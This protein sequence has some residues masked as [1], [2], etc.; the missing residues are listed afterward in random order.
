MR[1]P[2]L[3][4]FSLSLVATMALAQ[5]AERVAKA[6]EIAERLKLDDRI[7]ALRDA[8]RQDAEASV[9]V[10]LQQFKAAGLSEQ[11]YAEL[12]QLAAAVVQRI[13][14]SSYGGDAKERFIL[15]LASRAE[16][17]ELDFAAQVLTHETG[18]RVVGAVCRADAAMT[19]YIATSAE[20]ASRV[21]LPEFLRRA[22]ALVR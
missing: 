12:Q 4:A 3:A 1:T 14:D 8:T 9:S 16:P 13:E 18:A 21:E 6:S 10:V 5:P 7:D 22:R 15:T 2:R 17:D 11:A 20:R 19:Q